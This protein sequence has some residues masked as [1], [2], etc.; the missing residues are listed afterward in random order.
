MSGKEEVLQGT[1]QRP[2]MR[3]HEVL[4]ACMSILQETLS[5]EKLAALLLFSLAGSLLPAI[6]VYVNKWIIDA[7]EGFSRQEI[8]IEDVLWCIALYA[9]TGL[10]LAGITTP[11]ISPVLRI[12]FKKISCASPPASGWPIMMTLLI[13]IKSASPPT[14]CRCA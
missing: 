10:M 1:V 8:S 6:V 3:I 9:A 11:S 4:G 12:S 13:G 14:T 5:R 2:L 7:A